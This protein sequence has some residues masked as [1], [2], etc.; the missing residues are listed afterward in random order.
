MEGGC[1]DWVGGGCP[2]PVPA[3]LGDGVSWLILLTV[4]IAAALRCGDTV[5]V[6]LEPAHC[7]N[8]ATYRLHLAF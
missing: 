7:K 3:A 6:L 4:H 5:S 8:K 2:L 1:S